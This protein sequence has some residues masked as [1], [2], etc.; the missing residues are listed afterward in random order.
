MKTLAAAIGLAAI[1]ASPFAL[2][3]GQDTNPPVTR[4]DE[5]VWGETRIDGNTHTGYGEV[6]PG[7]VGARR[8]SLLRIR[9]HFHPELL[10]S[11]ENI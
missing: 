5:N 10:K 11:I 8:S 6:T 7:R 1:L 3:Q 4:Y 2:A 9:T